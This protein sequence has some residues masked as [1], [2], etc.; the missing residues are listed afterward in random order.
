MSWNDAKLMWEQSQTVCIMHVGSLTGG[1]C[2]PFHTCL[3]CV[4]PGSSSEFMRVHEH[5]TDSAHCRFQGRYCPELWPSKDRIYSLLQSS[6]IQS[7]CVFVSVVCSNKDYFVVTTTRR[8]E[9][10]WAGG[11][12]WQLVTQPL[13]QPPLTIPAVPEPLE[14]HKPL[15]C[16]TQSSSSEPVLVQVPCQGSA[17]WAAAG[18]GCG[19]SW[20]TRIPRCEGRPASTGSQLTLL[21]CLSTQLRAQPQPFLTK[22]NLWGP[23]VVSC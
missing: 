15:C 23:A 17:T 5:I 13:T 4:V 10:C 9:G 3:I 6:F 8:Q 21:R 2:L 20:V 16:S 11:L 22:H 1:A 14:Q 7:P 18:L 12:A 19:R